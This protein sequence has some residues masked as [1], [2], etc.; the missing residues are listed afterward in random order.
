MSLELDRLRKGNMYA[1]GSIRLKHVDTI[2]GRVF[3]A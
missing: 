2:F 3:G 1:V